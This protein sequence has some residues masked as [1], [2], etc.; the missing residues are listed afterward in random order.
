MKLASAAHL[1]G[2]FYLRVEPENFQD[3]FTLKALPSHLLPQ[4]PGNWQTFEKIA[5]RLFSVLKPSKSPF[6]PFIVNRH[7]PALNALRVPMFYFSHFYFSGFKDRIWS[8]L[9][10]YWGCDGLWHWRTHICCRGRAWL[11]HDPFNIFVCML[12][13]FVCCLVCRLLSRGKIIW[14]GF[15]LSKTW[16]SQTDK[17]AE[18]GI[19]SK[20][21]NDSLTRSTSAARKMQKLSELPVTSQVIAKICANH[22]TNWW[23]M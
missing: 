8:I 12:S 17:V 22:S 15:E 21:E 16:L 19:I 2:R 3:H 23:K 1:F 4:D 11:L 20:P 7:R 5:F 14:S 6:W 18:Q 10:D 13:L 9:S